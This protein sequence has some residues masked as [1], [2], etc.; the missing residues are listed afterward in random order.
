MNMK[1]ATVLVGALFLSTPLSAGEICDKFAAMRAEVEKASTKEG[2][3]DVFVLDGTVVEIA[4][5]VFVGASPDLE[6]ARNTAFVVIGTKQLN[7]RCVQ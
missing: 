7:F 2:V 3:A 4:R 1:I 6:A 5:A